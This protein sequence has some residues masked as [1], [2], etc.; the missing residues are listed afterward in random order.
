MP[1][2][3]K[4]LV[5]SALTLSMI[6]ALLLSGCSSEPEPTEDAVVE[7]ETPAQ[8]V[9]ESTEPR[10]STT[11]NAPVMEELPSGS[12]GARHRFVPD[13]EGQLEAAGGGL[14]SIIDGS[15]P[16]AFNES[17]QWI[18]SDTSAEQYRE[19]ESAI[20]FLNVYDP[21]VLGNDAKMRERLNGLTGQEVIDLAAQVSKQRSGRNN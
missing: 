20:R 6:A 2:I 4:P 21:A 18:A 17:L 7:P 15:S 13:V 19:L 12:T 5:L 9:A 10:P 11:T 3:R 14:Q 8:T 16:N 1:I